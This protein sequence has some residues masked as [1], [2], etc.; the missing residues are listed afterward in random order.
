MFCFFFQQSLAEF[1]QDGR[2]K[3]GIG[4]FETEHVLPIQAS[5]NGIRCLLIGKPLGKLHE[6]DQQQT[7][8]CFCRLPTSWKQMGKGFILIEGT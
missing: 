7:P 6:A 8:W 1:T 3:A 4:E 5:T 2:I